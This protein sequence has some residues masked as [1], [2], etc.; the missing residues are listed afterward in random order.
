MP[1]GPYIELAL[2]VQRAV[3][4]LAEVCKV[5]ALAARL[6]FYQAFS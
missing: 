3:G 1:C 5:L 2:E 6:T 4:D